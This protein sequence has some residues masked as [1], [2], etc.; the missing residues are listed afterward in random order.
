MKGLKR[1]S[2]F[3][4]YR[5][6]SGFEAFK[7]RLAQELVVRKGIYL[8]DFVEDINLYPFYRAGESVDFTIESIFATSDLD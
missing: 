7:K 8:E 6:H 2:A 4:F 5:I 1:T 3:S